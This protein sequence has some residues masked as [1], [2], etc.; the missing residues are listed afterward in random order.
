MLKKRP[1]I[2]NVSADLAEIR[3]ATVGEFL[4]KKRVAL[5]LNQIE[6]AGAL[7]YLSGQFVS[8]WERGQALPPP[9]ALPLLAEILEIE[10]R[11]MI[12][13]VCS[14]ELKGLSVHRAMLTRL[15][16]EATA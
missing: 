9:T 12:E 4:R 2:S 8:N 3:K 16:S 14:C 13:R 6:V 1:M 5:G 15:F 11:E 7:G 10:P